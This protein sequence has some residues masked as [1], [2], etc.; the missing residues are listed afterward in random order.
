MWLEPVL[1]ENERVGIITV[2]VFYTF[3]SVKTG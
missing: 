2:K 3:A 1:S